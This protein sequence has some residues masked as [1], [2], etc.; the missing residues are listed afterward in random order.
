MSTQ[1]LFEEEQKFDQKWVRI[2]LLFVIVPFEFLLTYGCYKQLFLGEPF[3]TSPAFD[4]GLLIIFISI[5]ILFTFLIWL[6][7]SI[8]LSVKVDTKNL[9]IRYYPFVNKMIPIE[10]I[11]SIELRTYKPIAEYGG[12]GIRLSFKGGGMGYI[13]S[14]NEGVRIQ[15]INR[16]A[17]LIGSQRAKELFDSLSKSRRQEFC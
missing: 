17:F 4:T 12:W 15:P 13:V 1:I 5:N 10:K 7:L 11:K 16:G 3:G 8:K 2:V 9:C 14:G 6:F